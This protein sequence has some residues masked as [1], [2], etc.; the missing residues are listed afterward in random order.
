MAKNPTDISEQQRNLLQQLPA[1]D[2]LIDLAQTEASFELVP[3]S[4][5]V[6]CIRAVLDADR[7]RIREG[8]GALTTPDLSDTAVMQRVKAAVRDVM[9]PKL[10]RV[11]NA[12]GW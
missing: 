9:R 3:K 10:L 11:V 12:T 1:V 4:V 2:R 8:N 7:R 5:V 6:N